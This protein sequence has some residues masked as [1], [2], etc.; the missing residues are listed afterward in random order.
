MPAMPAAALDTP[1][2]SLPEVVLHDHLDGILRPHPP[3]SG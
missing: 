3:P 2:F 1:A